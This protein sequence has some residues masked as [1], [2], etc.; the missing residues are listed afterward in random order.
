MTRNWFQEVC[1]GDGMMERGER[2]RKERKANKRCGH[3]QVTAVGN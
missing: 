2:H 3:G 1:L